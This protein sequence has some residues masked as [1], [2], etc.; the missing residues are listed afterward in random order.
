MPQT[1]A[2]A[3]LFAAAKPALDPM[4]RAG[5]WYPVVEELDGQ[6]VIE[7]SDERVAVPANLIEIR[8]KRPKLFTVVRKAI[9]DP[10]PAGGTP[11]DPGRVYAVCPECDGRTKLFGEPPVIAC[12]HCGHRGEVAWWD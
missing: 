4:P 5:A 11:A 12:D 9:G 7:V 1:A 3:R 10:N 6:V 2:W 8:E